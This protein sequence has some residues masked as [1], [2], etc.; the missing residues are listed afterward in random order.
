MAG[1]RLDEE[2]LQ[3]SPLKYGTRQ[4][5]G[6]SRAWAVS[7]IL[8]GG[9]PE[10]ISFRSSDPINSVPQVTSLTLNHFNG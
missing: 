4:N 2:G 6:A 7:G 1:I 9:S 8:G 5:A 3:M 10:A